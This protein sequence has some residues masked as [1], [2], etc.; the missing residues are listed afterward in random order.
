[1]T[2]VSHGQLGGLDASTLSTSS[3][4]CMIS[5]EAPDTM[6]LVRASILSTRAIP[7]SD[8]KV[9]MSAILKLLQKFIARC[10]GIVTAAKLVPSPWQHPVHLLHCFMCSHTCHDY[11]HPQMYNWAT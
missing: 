8:L 2:T 4:A 1:M 7:V 10:F 11:T 5:R 9:A 3:T 6:T